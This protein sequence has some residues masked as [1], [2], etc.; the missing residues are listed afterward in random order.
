MKN[1]RFVIIAAVILALAYVLPTNLPA[2]SKVEKQ[3][4][5]QKVEQQ[6]LRQ[7][8]QAQPLA[9]AAIEKAAGYAVFSDMGI[10][11]LFGGTG[12]GQGVVVNNQ[13]QEGES[14]ILPLTF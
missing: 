6:T 8:Y 1:P 3:E 7:L 4:D 2:E 10:K 11:I 13:T 14:Q 12:N 5:I 9:K